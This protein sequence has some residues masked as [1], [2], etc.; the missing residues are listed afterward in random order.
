M[1]FTEVESIGDDSKQELLSAKERSQFIS[2]G[3]RSVILEPSLVK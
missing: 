3:S 2:S 1:D